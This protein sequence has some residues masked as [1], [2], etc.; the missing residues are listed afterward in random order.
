[1]ERLVR[2]NGYCLS[3]AIAPPDRDCEKGNRG[4]F[5]FF[6]FPACSYFFKK[7]SVP[8]VHR[9]GWREAGL[10]SGELT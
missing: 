8:E 3:S 2:P 4:P 9:K 10:R 6:H 5:F 7:T 1:V